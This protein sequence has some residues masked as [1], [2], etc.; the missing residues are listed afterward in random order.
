MQ[1]IY[2]KNNVLNKDTCED[3]IYTFEASQNLYTTNFEDSTKKSTDIMF[4]QDIY[5]LPEWNSLID[6]MIISLDEGLKEYVEKFEVLNHMNSFS[7]STFNMQKY[8]PSEGFYGWHCERNGNKKYINRMLV[9]MIYLNDVKD[10]G[11]EFLYQNHKVEAEQGKLLI[12][13]SDW[14]HTHRGIISNQQT[15]YI[16]TGW[17]SYNVI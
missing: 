13:P 8:N 10:G 7:L 4:S 12:W 16:L 1:F 9:W 15:K 3:F 6:S 2:S 17:Y 14:T 5:K 11:T